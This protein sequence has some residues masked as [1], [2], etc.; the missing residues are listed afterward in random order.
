LFPFVKSFWNQRPLRE[1]KPGI[2]TNRRVK[3]AAKLLIIVWTLMKKEEPYNI[4]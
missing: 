4:G 2:K 1:T 3:L